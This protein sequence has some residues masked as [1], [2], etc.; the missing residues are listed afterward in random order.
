MP[1][2]GPRTGARAALRN[3]LLEVCFGARRPPAPSSPARSPVA[4]LTTTAPPARQNATQDGRLGDWLLATLLITQAF[5][6]P[7]YVVP[8]LERFI[9]PGDPS[10]SYPHVAVPLTEAQKWAV[11][12]LAPLAAGLACNLP[13]L[14]SSSS[15]A[16]IAATDVHHVALAAYQAF[17]I[18]ASFKKWINLVGRPRPDFLARVASGKDEDVREGLFAYPSG[19]AAEFFAVGTV[20]S[21]YFMGRARLLDATAPLRR[22][23]GHLAT[24]AVCLLPLAVATV[25]A[26]SRVAGYRHDF[27][28]IN[29]GAG[30]GFLCGWF[31]YLLN[32]ASPTSKQCGLPRL[33]EWAAE[34][35]GRA[36]APR[37]RG[38]KSERAEPLL[39]EEEEEDARS[40]G[41]EGTAAD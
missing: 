6:L 28:D 3:V 5:I 41:R 12:A 11:L 2:T 32:F 38:R 16:A 27:S 19:H 35:M 1:P 31:A 18:E 10:V 21:L 8:P 26:M 25:V 34:I 20:L 4:P 17:A 15:S 40:S 37:R 24:A 13:L 30:L 23:G 33:G 39:V 22:A 36:Q 29:A 9:P 14:F 7:V